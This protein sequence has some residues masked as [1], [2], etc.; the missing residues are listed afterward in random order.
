MSTV[1]LMFSLTIRL[2][3]CTKASA[4]CCRKML[5]MQASI[6]FSSHGSSEVTSFSLWKHRQKKKKK[7]TDPCG[8]L[9]YLISCTVIPKELNFLKN[10]YHLAEDTVPSAVQQVS[11][12]RDAGGL[13]VLPTLWRGYAHFHL[14]PLYKRRL[15]LC[16]CTKCTHT[17]THERK[18]M[19]V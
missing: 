19:I 7:V 6:S 4:S 11:L 16:F 13:P 18:L 9:I 15:L 12:L 14:A 3:S 5:E 1:P 2:K 10:I 17:H 8:T